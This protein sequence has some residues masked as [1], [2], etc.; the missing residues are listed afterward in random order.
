MLQREGR[1]QIV[2]T[3]TQIYR[4]IGKDH[5]YVLNLFNFKNELKKSI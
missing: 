1:N 4:D 2:E 3:F 5:V